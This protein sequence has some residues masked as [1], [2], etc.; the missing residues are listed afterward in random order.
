MKRLFVLAALLLAS[1][2]ASAQWAGDGEVIVE[3]TNPTHGIDNE[4]GKLIPLDA[5]NAITK[6]KLWFSKTPMSLPLP[7][8][9]TV[10]LTAT[11]PLQTE[12]TYAGLKYGDTVYV[13]LIGCNKYGCS[14]PSNEARGTIPYRP[15]TPGA[16]QNVTIR[17]K[18]L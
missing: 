12:Y 11:V 17:I 7:E 4:T 16:V 9:P 2:V 8:A 14:P 13:R 1:S 3:W 10:E 6:Y 18:L 15:N 5:D